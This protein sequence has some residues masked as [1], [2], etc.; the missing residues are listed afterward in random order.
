MV[1]LD[2]GRE[3]GSRIKY[4]RIGP[5]LAYFQPTLLYSPPLPLPP[6]SIQTTLDSPMTTFLWRP[7]N[8]PWVRS[9]LTWFQTYISSIS[10]NVHASIIKWTICCSVCIWRIDVHI[11]KLFKLNEILMRFWQ[12][13]LSMHGLSL[14][15]EESCNWDFVYLLYKLMVMLNNYICWRYGAGMLWAFYCA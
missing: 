13:N 4:S 15:I 14:C 2:W 8:C 12:K 6:P 5:K 11:C 10:V 9:K 7:S 3:K 1:C